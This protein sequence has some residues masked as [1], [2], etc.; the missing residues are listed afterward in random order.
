MT[1][2]GRLSLVTGKGGVGKSTVAAVLTQRALAHG[3]ARLLQVGEN[4]HAPL[5]V[6]HTS[7]DPLNAVAEVASQLLRSRTLARFITRRPTIAAFL[8]IAHGIQAFSVLEYARQYVAKGE[9]VVLDL[10]AT[11]HA[12]AWVRSVRI[13]RRVALQGL[14]HDLASR[15]ESELFHERTDV[16]VVTLPERFVWKESAELQRKLHEEGLRAHLVVN[17][18]PPPTNASE[19]VSPEIAAPPESA[20]PSGIA[21]FEPWR[22]EAARWSAQRALALQLQPQLMLPLRFPPDPSALA[23]ELREVA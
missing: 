2:R 4:F 7:I 1:R 15:L 19:S 23:A 16:Y 17:R 13:L 22:A 18:V 9:H 10:P 11:G 21:A 8:K 14:A 3:P 20:A 12:L 6:P 5:G